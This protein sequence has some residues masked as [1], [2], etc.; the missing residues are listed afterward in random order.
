MSPCIS[1]VNPKKIGGYDRYDV[2]DAVRAMRKSAE[3]EADPKF[4]K[5]VAK[6]MNK[7][8][9]QLVEKASLLTKTSAKLKAVFGGKK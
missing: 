8:A 3:I 6:E 2:E 9:G 1:E 7:E 4:R 5:V